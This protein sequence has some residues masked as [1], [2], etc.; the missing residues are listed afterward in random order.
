MKTITS[1]SFQVDF[2]QHKGTP[3]SKFCMVF[4]VFNSGQISITLS[5]C[6]EEPITQ[7]ISPEAFKKYVDSMNELQ[8]EYDKYLNAKK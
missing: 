1:K 8:C 5:Y 6:D 4:S 2:G 7:I 3:Y